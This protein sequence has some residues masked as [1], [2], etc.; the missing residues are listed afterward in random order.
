MRI[1][2]DLGRRDGVDMEDFPID[3]V[4]KP[5]NIYISPTFPKTEGKPSQRNWLCYGNM[6][7]T[8]NWIWRQIVVSILFD[9][10]QVGK[11]I[12]ANERF[13]FTPKIQFADLRNLYAPQT[14]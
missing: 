6:K 14:Y 12:Y 7:L 4:I 1:T 10:S 8:S 13:I 2:R 11:Y 3:R 5:F 9:I